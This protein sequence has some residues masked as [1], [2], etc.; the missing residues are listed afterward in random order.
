MLRI[1]KCGYQSCKPRNENSCVSSNEVQMKLFINFKYNKGCVT[2]YLTDPLKAQL[3]NTEL[4]FTFTPSWN[5][6]LGT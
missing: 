6:I 3:E 4:T 5:T 2:F 1:S